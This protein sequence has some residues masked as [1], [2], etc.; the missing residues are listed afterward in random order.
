MLHFIVTEV[1]TTSSKKVQ[2]GD[3]GVNICEAEN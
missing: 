2:A 3:L 1:V